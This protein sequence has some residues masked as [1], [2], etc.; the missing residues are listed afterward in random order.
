MSKFIISIEGNIGSGKGN[1]V[2]FL[3]KYFKDNISYSEESVFNWENEELI[4]KFY[5]DQKRWSF[6]MEVNS[7]VK[8]I[9]NMWNLISVEKNKVIVSTRC[10]SSDKDCFLK[11]LYDMENITKKEY[12]TYLEMFEILK[13]PKFNVII[14]LK[15][16]VNTCYER[17]ISKHRESEKNLSFEFIKNL[18]ISYNNWIDIL[19]KNNVCVV[20][21]DMEKYND[22]EGNEEI[23]EN[24][25][26]ILL[27]KI[28]LLDDYLK[29][30]HYKKIYRNINA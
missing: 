23:Q 15:S 8:K 4:K 2:R 5:K 19:E 16:N 27:D 24:V 3:Q 22:I 9:K 21:I 6:L 11:T 18:N 1:F 14:Y 26:K 29:W 20:T 28:P 17:V 10:P 25:L 30:N 13:M 12:E 7:V